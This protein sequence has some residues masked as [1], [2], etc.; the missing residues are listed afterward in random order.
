MFCSKCGTKLPD[1]AKFCKN[2]GNPVDPTPNA[3]QPQTAADKPQRDVKEEPDAGKI[4][5][6]GSEY[7][8]RSYFQAPAFSGEAVLGTIRTGA[9]RA[10]TALLPGPLKTAGSGFR[11]FFSSVKNLFKDPV[12]MIPAAALALLWLV[13]N[14]IQAFGIN[15]LPLRILSFITFANG[16]MSGGIAGAMGGIIGKGVY[17]GAVTAIVEMI[18]H[19]KNRPKRSFPDVIK[20]SLGVSPDSLWGY[21]TG[22]GASMLLFLLMSGGSTRISFMCGIASAFMAGRSALNN[23]FLNR[24]TVS[25]SSKGRSAATPEASGLMKG[26]SAGFAASSFIGLLNIGLILLIAGAVLV[27]GGSVM[28]ILQ[29]AGAVKIGKTEKTP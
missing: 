27:L 23:G 24:F 28:M 7:P 1:H 4:N 29:A 16:G 9:A 14:I 20:G 10:G 6:N 5:V 19:W 26:L 22:I 18:R 15:P 8:R 13:L 11:S 3:N 21:L 12:R 2:C 25:F 17:A